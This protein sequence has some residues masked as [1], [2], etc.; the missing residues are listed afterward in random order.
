M[1]KKS[2]TAP[3]QV[4]KNTNTKGDSYSRGLVK[5]EHFP[6]CNSTSENGLSILPYGSKSEYNDGHCN[7]QE[8]EIE[9][10]RGRQA[11]RQTDRQRDRERHRDIER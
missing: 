10:E 3:R 6:L 7:E 4:L 2:P 11:G 1:S 8:R 5:F 9:R